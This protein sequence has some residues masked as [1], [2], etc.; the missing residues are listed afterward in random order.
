M[1]FRDSQSAQEGH[2]GQRHVPK[3][4]RPRHSLAHGC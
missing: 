3:T 2:Q 1:H 4:L